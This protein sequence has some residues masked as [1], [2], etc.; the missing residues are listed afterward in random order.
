MVNISLAIMPVQSFS[1]FTETV[2][3]AKERL[4][5]IYSI[6]HLTD[7]KVPDDLSTQ[8]YISTFKNIMSNDNGIELT[9][10]EIDVLATLFEVWYNFIFS[11][12]SPI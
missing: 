2:L 5:A 11:H 4:F 7:R 8:Q 1:Y 12:N 6:I 9:Y 10:Q 3:S